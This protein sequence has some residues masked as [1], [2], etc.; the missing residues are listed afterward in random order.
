M[1]RFRAY[2][3]LLSIVFMFT[4]FAAP[5][6]LRVGVPAD[7]PPISF[8]DGE[9]LPSG[10]SVDM[11]EQIA[12]AQHLSF[13]YV[14]LT[15]DMAKNWQA[16]SQNKLDVLLGPVAVD[17][18]L[19]QKV[20]YSLPYFINPVSVAMP[21]KAV[22]LRALISGAIQDYM[23]LIV[24]AYFLFFFIYINIIWFLERFFT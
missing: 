6:S 23:V 2:F 4:A 22:R 18:T 10:L 17:V 1:K 5:T 8:I 24:L 13:T 20:G 9:G 21:K 15:S 7:Y 11:W 19:L 12:K 14:I 3:L 16:I